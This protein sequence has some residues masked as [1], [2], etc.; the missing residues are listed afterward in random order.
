MPADA[1]PEIT[2]GMPEM[3]ETTQLPVSSRHAAP[4]PYQVQQPGYPPRTEA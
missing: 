3:S 2:A 4:G 1:A